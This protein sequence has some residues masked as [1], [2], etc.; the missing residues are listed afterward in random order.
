MAWG[1]G[2][3][4]LSLSPASGT[5]CPSPRRRALPWTL[6]AKLLELPGGDVQGQYRIYWSPLLCKRS[7]RSL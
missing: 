7:L 2:G 3:A 6:C 5:P 4:C 1:Q